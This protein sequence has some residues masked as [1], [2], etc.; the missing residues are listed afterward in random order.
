[1]N[2]TTKKTYLGDG[3]YARMAGGMIVLEAPRE[4]RHPL[5]GARARGL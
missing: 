5:G 3:L 4:S 2:E 1:M